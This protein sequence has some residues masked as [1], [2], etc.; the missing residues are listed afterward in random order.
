MYSKLAAVLFFFKTHKHTP[1]IP[2][3]LPQ[4]RTKNTQKS[5]THSFSS[6]HYLV[7]NWQHHFRQQGGG[8]AVGVGGLLPIA[9]PHNYSHANYQSFTT[10]NYHTALFSPRPLFNGSEKANGTAAAAA[11]A[12]KQGVRLHWAHS[13]AEIWN[14]SSRKICMLCIT[15]Q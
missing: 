14:A 12:A 5:H 13:G 9:K 2:S 8:L 4:L 15:K 3:C 1:L 11:V 10:T 6:S 7:N